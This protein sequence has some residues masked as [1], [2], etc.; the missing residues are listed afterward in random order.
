M[1]PTLIASVAVLWVAIASTSF[2]DEKLHERPFRSLSV[3]VPKL[4]QAPT[5]DG[6]VDAAEWAGAGMMPRMLTF[7]SD[8]HLSDEAGKFYIGYTDDALWLAW[9]IQR[10]KDAVAPKAVI[11]QPD[12]SFW[13]TDDA[14]ELMLNC[15]P[16]GRDK[17]NNRDYY[18]IWNARGTKYD[19]RDPRLGPGPALAWTGDWKAMSRTVPDFGWGGGVRI[20]LDILVGAEK[21]AGGARWRFQLC[22]NL[23]TPDAKVL[24]AGFQMNWGA[25]RDYP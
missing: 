16:E 23:A 7:E 8:D 4:A 17:M 3:S 18:M 9:Q 10:P 12:R 2:A 19:R 21:P 20:P 1:K 15:T 5:L 24:L 6:T 14:I 13:H 11:T 22:Q 25:L